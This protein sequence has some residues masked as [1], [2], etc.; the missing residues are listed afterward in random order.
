VIEIIVGG[1]VLRGR[2]VVIEP[3]RELIFALFLVRRIGHRSCPVWLYIVLIEGH[4]RGI[5]TRRRDNAVRENRVI[6]NRL[7]RGRTSRQTRQRRECRRSGRSSDRARTA[8]APL[9]LLRKGRSRYVSPERLRPTRRKVPIGFLCCWQDNL[10]GRNAL[11]Q[12]VPLVR[13]KQKTLILLDGTAQRRAKLILLV[14]GYRGVKKAL[15]VQH[16][17]PKKFVEITVYGVGSG[18]RDHVDHRTRVAPILRVE[19]VRQYPEF[20]DRIR[21]RL[22]GWSVHENIVAVS[23]VHHVVVRPPAAAIHRYNPGAAAAVKQVSAQLRL[24]AR[25]QLQHLIGIARIER[26]F[27]HGLVGH[28]G[29]QLCRRGVNHRR[30]ARDFDRVHVRADLQRN[31]DRGNL[32]QNQNDALADILLE[33]LLIYIHFVA[34]N[35]HFEEEVSTGGGSLHFT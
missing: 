32:V 21:R 18:F 9:Q 17:V 11:T 12:A 10:P 33:S 8:S 16:L 6:T 27:A 29:A 1:K 2:E 4:G 30:R 24:H 25:L 14:V 3:Q 15:G 31:V 22:D 28:H 19:G 7:C 23:A 34:A 13:C 26:E 35:R 20:L 5:K